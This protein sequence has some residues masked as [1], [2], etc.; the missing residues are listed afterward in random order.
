M[1]RGTGRISRPGVNS[2]WEGQEVLEI[3][4]H[5]EERREE[6]DARERTTRE[7]KERGASPYFVKDSDYL[8]GTR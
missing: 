1:V 6:G 3:A 4:G 8:P 2:W 7:G 5:V